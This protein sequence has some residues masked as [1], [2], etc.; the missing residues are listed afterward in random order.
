MAFHVLIFDCWGK[1]VIFLIM[2][3]EEMYIVCQTNFHLPFGGNPIPR[4]P[5]SEN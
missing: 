2:F 1:I 5:V 4:F 3:C